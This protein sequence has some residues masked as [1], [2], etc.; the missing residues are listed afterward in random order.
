MAD[1]EADESETYPYTCP[2]EV[3]TNDIDQNGHV[4]NTAY[5]VYFEQARARYFRS[6]LE[7]E[8]GGASVVVAKLEIEYLSPVE[9]EDDVAV[10]VRVSEV[11]SSSWTVDCRLRANDRVA[12]TGR[13]VH[14]AWDRENATSQSIPE[15]WREKMEAELVAET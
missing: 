15:A 8:W 2:I 1:Q 14:V 10:D 4:N 9:F 6:L 7:N 5:S 3:R 11:G 12:A 13:S